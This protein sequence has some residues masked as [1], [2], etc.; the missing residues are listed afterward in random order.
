V[1]DASGDSIAGFE[2]SVKL[3]VNRTAWNLRRDGFERP[4]AG[5]GGEE[6][7]SF[8]GGGFG[9][10]VL[11]GT[12]TVTLEY[13]DH[14]ASGA[15]EVLPDPRYALTMAQ[16]REKHDALMHAGHVQEALAEAVGR[17]RGTRDEI[18]KLL[19]M[20]E[21][22]EEDSSPAAA[23]G[24]GDAPDIR[25]DAT[26]LKKTLTDLEER[27]WTPPGTAKGIA[28]DTSVYSRVRNAY[29]SMSSS[30]DPPTEGQL[31][32]LRQAEDRLRTVFDEVNRVYAEDVARFRA[33]VEEVGTAFLQERE[34]LDVPER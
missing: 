7:F 4:R 32:Y 1:R 5:G 33:R 11:P 19:G 10:E 24:Q 9:P 3:G 21:E 28:R 23:E 8:F 16:R 14:E 20:L 13:G 31:I 30:W 12:Y 2:Q 22:A 29:S 34:P 15:V 6:E 25:A 17:L 26:A 18:D 27:L